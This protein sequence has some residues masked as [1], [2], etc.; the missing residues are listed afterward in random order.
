MWLKVKK[1][2]HLTKCYSKLAKVLIKR[3]GML[4]FYHANILISNQTDPTCDH[5]PLESGLHQNIPEFS[6]VNAKIIGPSILFHHFAS[7]LIGL[8]PQN[9]LGPADRES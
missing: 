1:S 5:G 2:T 7:S 4:M 6:A 3:I 9:S 8:A